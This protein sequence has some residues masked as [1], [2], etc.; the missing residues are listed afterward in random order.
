MKETRLNE[1]EMS[2]SWHIVRNSD[3]VLFFYLHQQV[4]ELKPVTV[5]FDFYANELAGQQVDHERAG[6]K[7]RKCTQAG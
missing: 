6:N 4:G 3:T 1:I 2:T 5:K 7:L